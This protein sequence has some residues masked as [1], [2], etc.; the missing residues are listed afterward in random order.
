MAKGSY[1]MTPETLEQTIER[2]AKSYYALEFAQRND[3]NLPYLV[4]FER[5]VQHTLF[6]GKL[7]PHIKPEDLLAHPA[8]SN[9]IEALCH[10]SDKRIA[11]ALEPFQKEV[12]P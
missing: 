11:E 1:H 4:G 2:L 3:L 9:L 8:V 6:S 10:P 7:I 12:R 5:G